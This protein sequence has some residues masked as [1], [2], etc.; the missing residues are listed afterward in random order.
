MTT[1]R[2]ASLA[3]LATLVI[4]C[5]PAPFPGEKEEV[6]AATRDVPPE[7]RAKAVQVC[8][9]LGA[10]TT[11]WFWD[12]ESEDW[13]VV[14]EGMSRIAELDVLPSGEF[15]ELELVY[16]L[17]EVEEIL[18]GVAVSI[19]EKCRDD[20]DVLIELSL[21]R[22]EYLKDVPDLGF[23]WTLSGVVLEFQCPNG[24]DFEL[25]AKNMLIEH[26]VDDIGED[27]SDHTG[28]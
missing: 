10:T 21:R 6:H 22:E 18:P 23:A 28:R 16:T 19:R 17:A 25:D 1:S 27:V 20:P 7:V 11:E 26:P 4:G 9:L 5:S 3:I 14:L 15:S 8:E 12:R 24:R 2:I 13:E